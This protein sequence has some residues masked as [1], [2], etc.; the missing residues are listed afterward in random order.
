MGYD[1]DADI[2][3]ILGSTAREL[4]IKDVNVL[5][6]SRIT[7]SVTAAPFFHQQIT[8]EGGNIPRLD[9]NPNSAEKFSIFSNSGIA[10]LEN[11]ETSNLGDIRFRVNGFASALTIDKDKCEWKS[12]HFTSW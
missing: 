9:F 3:E 10:F 4:H 5:K 12:Y 2:Y 7:G 1:K 11:T 6:V 8:I